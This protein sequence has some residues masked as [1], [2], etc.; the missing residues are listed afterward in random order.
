MVPRAQHPSFTEKF[1]AFGLAY[2]GREA[3]EAGQTDGTAA[4]F[5]TRFPRRR[6]VCRDFGIG[7]EMD[8]LGELGVAAHPIAFAS[9]VD[10]VAAV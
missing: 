1:Q 9:D 10:N 8:H 5:M 6:E 3:T 2:E 4:T 7:G